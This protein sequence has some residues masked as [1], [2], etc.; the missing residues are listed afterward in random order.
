MSSNRL[1]SETSFQHLRE[2]RGLL[3]QLHKAL[4]ESERVEYERLNGPVQSRGEFFQLVIGH[5]WFNWLR[6]ISQYIVQIDEAMSAKEPMTLSTAD[7]L[8][9]DGRSLLHSLQ[10]G[11]PSEQRYQQAIQRDPEIA[12]M[13]AEVLKLLS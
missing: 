11:T 1:P 9:D 4:L 10:A 5:E 3:L 7:A 8:L 13:H 6:P 12:S 2:L